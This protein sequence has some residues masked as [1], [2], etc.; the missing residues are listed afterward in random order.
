MKEIGPEKYYERIKNTDLD[1]ILKEKDVNTLFLVG[2]S[3]TGCVLATYFGGIDHDLR[4]SLPED[5]QHRIGVQ[6]I[7]DFKFK[8]QFQLALAP[9]RVIMHVLE[10]EEQL[11]ALNTVYEHLQPGGTF[12]FDTFV[13][14]LEQL[15][16]GLNEFVDFE[17]EY[18]PG[19]KLKRITSTEPDLINQVIN[20]TFRFEWEED[21]LKTFEWEV[22]LRFFFRYELE[23]LLERSKFESY[24][25]LGDYEG[26]LLNKNSK[27]FISVCKKIN[28]E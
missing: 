9:F 19:K 2:L 15:L 21:E 16:N 17:G 27:E 18:Q 6:C 4:E 5:Q 3:G 23:H 28:P 13:P 14:N 26:N 1:K 8:H 20:I 25:I 24:Q 12:I 7:V 10:K 22:P 11:K